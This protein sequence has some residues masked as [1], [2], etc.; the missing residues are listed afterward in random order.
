VFRHVDNS[1]V[2]MAHDLANWVRRMGSDV[3]D[4]LPDELQQR[5]GIRDGNGLSRRVKRQFCGPVYSSKSYIR[6]V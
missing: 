4:E 2:K 1:R 6:H 3:V 5:K